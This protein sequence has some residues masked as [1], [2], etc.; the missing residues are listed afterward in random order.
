M[1]DVIAGERGA[2]TTRACDRDAAVGAAPAGAGPGRRDGRSPRSFP[3][4][5]LS[6]T[7]PNTRR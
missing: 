3:R 6:R 1:S 4:R 7:S 2:Q 5:N